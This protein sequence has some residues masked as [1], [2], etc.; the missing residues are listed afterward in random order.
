MRV[1]SLGHEYPLQKKMA[2]P[3]SILARKSHRQR[4]LVGPIEW[5]HKDSDTIYW[6]SA[7]TQEHTHA[8]THTSYQSHKPQKVGTQVCGYTQAFLFDNLPFAN[9][10]INC[11][12]LNGIRNITLI[13]SKTENAPAYDLGG[14]RY[15]R[16]QDL[17]LTPYHLGQ[18]RRLGL[19][20]LLS[21]IRICKLGESFN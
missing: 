15:L 10:V 16:F 3:C 9:R 14:R 11:I 2:P 6:L 17:D 20:R 8:H 5:G 12:S 19:M 1:W 13:C 21:M 4:S 18:R 7:R